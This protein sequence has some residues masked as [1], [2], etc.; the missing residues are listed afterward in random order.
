[1]KETRKGFGGWAEE[2]GMVGGESEGNEER[3]TK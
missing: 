1:M 2:E 3:K